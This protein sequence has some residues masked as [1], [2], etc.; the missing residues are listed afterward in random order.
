MSELDRI[1][2]LPKRVGRSDFPH[3][4]RQIKQDITMEMTQ[5]GWSRTIV[6]RAI[7]LAKITLDEEIDRIETSIAA[8]QIRTPLL[9]GAED[10]RI[11]LDKRTVWMSAL[12]TRL[13]YHE[14]LRTKIGGYCTYIT[15]FEGETEYLDRLPDDIE[16]VVAAHYDAALD[17]WCNVL[18]RE[19]AKELPYDEM[20]DHQTMCDFFVETLLSRVN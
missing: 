12:N 10:S 5:N 6:R 7:D 2:P 14:T 17:E 19:V 1:Q 11:E 20:P 4:K 9:R 8:A 18:I 16:K 3:D 15:P 13:D